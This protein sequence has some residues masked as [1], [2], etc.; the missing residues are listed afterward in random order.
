MSNGCLLN[1]WGSNSRIDH[2][3]SPT[4]TGPYVFK[5]IAVNTW[6]HNAAP[7]ALK[8][9]T[10]VTP[11]SLANCRLLVQLGLLAR[12]LLQNSKKRNL[13]LFCAVSHTF[14]NSDIM[15]ITVVC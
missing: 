15:M 10:C 4:I 11:T 2:G 7:I 13:D 3:V 14:V 12:L 1:H 5:D 6:S 8:D 9:G